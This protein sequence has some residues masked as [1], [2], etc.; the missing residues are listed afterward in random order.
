MKNIVQTEYLEEIPELLIDEYLM[1]KE[2][3]LGLAFASQT[4][5][6]S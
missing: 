4:Q 1:I 6:D 2:A 3:A 5:I